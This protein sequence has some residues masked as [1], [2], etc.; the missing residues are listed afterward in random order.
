LAL[1]RFEFGDLD[2]ARESSEGVS[3]EI[4]V[5]P[6]GLERGGVPGGGG[7]G[8]LDRLVQGEVQLEVAGLP[9]D[10]GDECVDDLDRDA[11]EELGW[12]G[13][14]SEIEDAL[15]RGF[16]GGEVD[17]GEVLPPRSCARP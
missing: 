11:L 7:K 15:L 12:G 5:L 17:F 4:D 10:V 9:S 14:A 6:G 3:C 1:E 16:V 2:D 8:G 13:S